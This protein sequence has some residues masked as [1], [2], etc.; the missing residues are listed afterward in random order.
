MEKEKSR[1][2]RRKKR[3]KEEKERG[4]MTIILLIWF[5]QLVSWLNHLSESNGN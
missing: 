3:G 1:E 5:L 4:R 2:K